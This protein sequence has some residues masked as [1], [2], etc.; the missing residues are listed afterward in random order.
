MKGFMIGSITR[1]AIA[2]ED[3][4]AIGNALRQQYGVANPDPIV[5]RVLGGPA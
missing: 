2:G 3:R 1:L 4:E 5:D